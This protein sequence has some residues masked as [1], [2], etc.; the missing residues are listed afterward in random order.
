MQWK[1][2]SGKNTGAPKPKKGII[3]EW[4]DALVFALV[5]S[6]IFRGLLFSAYAI[7]SGSMEGTEVAGDH[8]FV[9]KLAYGP[10]MPYTPL[11]VPFLEPII[12]NQT[13]TYWDAIQLPYFRLPGLQKVKKGDVVV[14]NKPAEDD[15]PYDRPVDMKTVLIKRCQGTPGDVLS[16]KNGQVYINGKTAQNAPLQQTSYTVTTDGS[17]INPQLFTDWN[18]ELLYQTAANSYVMIIPAEHVAE[19]K[20]IPN[21]KSV[22]PYTEPAGNYNP[23]VFP[24]NPLLKWNEDNYGPITLPKQGMTIPLNDSTLAIYTRAITL[25]ENNKLQ[26][27][28]NTVLI[29]GKPAATYT[30]KQNYYW[31]MGDNR[32]NSLDSRFWGYVPETNIVG[33][34]VLTWL[35]L[36]SAANVFNR[37]RWNRTMRWIK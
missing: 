4:L 27:N 25:Y 17:Q 32:H 9:S 18:I 14:F 21:I 7:P 3:R 16:I 28:G 19:F 13:K 20:S 22:N 29:N 36:D 15:P 2:K 26:K 35:S 8:I 5:V 24:H 31:M 11:S 1:F 34:A 37:V 30:F 23:Q 33:K 6:T 10:R 12:G